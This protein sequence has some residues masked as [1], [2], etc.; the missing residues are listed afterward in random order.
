MT[1]S[2]IQTQIID[3]IFGF[4]LFVMHSRRQKWKAKFHQDES[5]CGY[6][7]SVKYDEAFKKIKNFPGPKYRFAM[8]FPERFSRSPSY[9]SLSFDRNLFI[10]HHKFNILLNDL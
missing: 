5:F 10:Q 6:S 8:G 2:L 9:E 4:H 3:L 7:K 1:V